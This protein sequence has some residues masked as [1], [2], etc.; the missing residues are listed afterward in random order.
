MAKRIYAV[1]GE[2]LEQYALTRPPGAVE[3]DGPR[4]G[5]E[6]V[7]QPDGT[8]AVPAPEPV[9]AIDPSDFQDR[10]TDDE[11]ALARRY[12]VEED[13]SG[14]PTTRAKGVSRILS[15]IWTVRVVNLDASTEAGKKTRALLDQ[16]VNQGVLTD[17][18]RVDEL[19]VPLAPQ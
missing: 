8:W 1:P 9:Y 4:P 6:Y 16:L 18:A 10:F 14:N 7:A 13:G 12:A 3:M 11:V 2:S 5:P 19:M 17:S 15:V